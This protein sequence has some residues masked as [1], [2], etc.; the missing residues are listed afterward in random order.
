[1]ASRQNLLQFAVCVITSKIT[2]L[3]IMF[4]CVIICI[5]LNKFI[6]S[7]IND[8]VRKIDVSRLVSMIYMYMDISLC[9]LPHPQ[10]TRNPDK[11]RRPT[12]TE[13]CSKLAL[14]PSHLLH[15]HSTSSCRTLTTHTDNVEYNVLLNLSLLLALQH[16][17]V[18]CEICFIIA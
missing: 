12:F 8:N 4:Y 5:K 3:I 9:F 10:L 17:G 6:S 2:K 14:P 1:M 18:S 11:S 15:T 16:S 13:L 7:K